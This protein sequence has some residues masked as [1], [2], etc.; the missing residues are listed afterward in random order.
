ML[1]YAIAVLIVPLFLY[2][3]FRYPRFKH[4][5]PL[6]RRAIIV[7]GA[8]SGIGLSTCQKLVQK[9][10]HVFALD[11]NEEFLTKNYSSLTAVTTIPVDVAQLSSVQ[12]A[13]EIISKEL[14]RKYS[15]GLL[16]SEHVFGLVTCA[17]ILYNSLKSIVEQDDGYMERMFSVNMFGT[18]YCVKTFYTLFGDNSVIILIG[19]NA[20]SFA[21]PF[22]SFYSASKAAV[23]RY[24][25][26]LR[27]EMIFR[28][29]VRVHCLNPGAASSTMIVGERGHPGVDKASD[30]KNEVT[31]FFGEDP[32]K[33]LVDL[34]RLQTPSSVADRVVDCLDSTNAPAHLMVDN[35]IERIM[36]FT[37][38]SFGPKLFD[39]VL[40]WL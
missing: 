11:I 16:E 3:F 6:K 33:R 35:F 34:G 22:T 12:S 5:V 40:K 10:C 21:V 9:G 32:Q 4:D 24:A 8:A 37:F 1:Y 19:S 17:G 18:H 13:R 14:K 20:G 31:R 36:Y 27:R 39:N 15:E 25:D 23:I 29:K 2:L 7:T 28:G 26:T 30:F 38:T